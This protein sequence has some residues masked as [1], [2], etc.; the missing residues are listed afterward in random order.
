MTSLCHAPPLK[1]EGKKNCKSQVRD[2]C[3]ETLFA[4]R[5]EVF[6]SMNSEPLWFH[7]QTCKGTSQPKMPV[8]IQKRLMNFHIQLRSCREAMAAGEGMLLFFGDVAPEGSR[9]TPAPVDGTY[10]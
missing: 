2:A 1:E 9:A 7:R 5:D 10:R 6:A 3:G 8:W 4:G